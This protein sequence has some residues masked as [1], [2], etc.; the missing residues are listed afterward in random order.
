MG[1]QNLT[2]EY[3]TLYTNFFW[4]PVIYRHTDTKR[5]QLAMFDI[6]TVCKGL[7]NSSYSLNAQ[8]EPSFFYINQLQ[9]LSLRY[10]LKSLKNISLRYYFFQKLKKNPNVTIFIAS[11]QTMKQNLF[12][13]SSTINFDTFVL[14]PRLYS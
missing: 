4:L 2:F 5:C 12:C 9:F 11:P 7:A 6:K 13:L 1:S 3:F 14:S 8:Y 10:F